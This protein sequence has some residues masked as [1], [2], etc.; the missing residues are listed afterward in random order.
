MQ[1]LLM[2]LAGCVLVVAYAAAARAQAPATPTTSPPPAAASPAAPAKTTPA[3][4]TPAQSNPAQSAPAK[5]AAV[6]PAPPPAHTHPSPQPGAIEVERAHVARYDA[7]IA[8][9][10]AHA[11]AP[12]DATRLQTVFARTTTRDLNAAKVARDE[13]GDPIA[14]KIADWYRLRSGFGEAQEYRQFMAANQAWPDR[15]LL[16]QRLDEA[17]FTQGGNSAAIK[18]HYKAEPPRTG[19]GY[20]ALASAHLAEGDEATALELARISWRDYDIGATLEAGFIGRFGKLLTEADHKWRFDRILADD[21]RWS[22]ERSERVAA[23]RRMLPLF[24]EAERKKADARLAVLSRAAN[25]AALM[26]AL[27]AEDERRLGPGVP[28]RAAT[29]ARRPDRG[30]GQAGA[31]RPARR[32]GHRLAGRLVGG[33]PRDRLR[34]AAARAMPSSPTTSSSRRRRC[35]PTRPRTRPSRPAGSRC[36]TCAMPPPPRAT[37]APCARSPTVP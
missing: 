4:S 26:A 23:A 22:A 6:T 18:E 13:L 16:T 27:P 9:A 20:A 5:T 15:N 14:R 25:A 2:S 35:P 10:T 11:V 36:N 19:T 33:A 34:G 29:P 8:A 37:S 12:A 30:G 7:A 21:P 24:A 1:K 32:Q 17:F 31:R 28:A 3:Q